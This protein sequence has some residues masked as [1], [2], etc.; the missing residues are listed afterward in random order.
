MHNKVLAARKLRNQIF[1]APFESDD[2][3]PDETPGKSLRKRKPEIR[4]P[5]FKTGDAPADN[6]RRKATPDGFNLGKFGHKV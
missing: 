5:R 6:N 4:A 3:L 2:L 1:G